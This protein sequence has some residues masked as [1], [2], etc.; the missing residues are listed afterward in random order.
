MSGMHKVML[1]DFILTEIT[2]RGELGAIISGC[3]R[4]PFVSRGAQG[5]E[6]YPSIG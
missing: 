5:E 3:E 2:L 1:P 4:G 6:D